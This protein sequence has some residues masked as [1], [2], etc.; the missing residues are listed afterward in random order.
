M[1]H[2]KRRE[3]GLGPVRLMTL[4]EASDAAPANRKVAR[5]GGDPRRTRRRSV[6][7]FERATAE[8]F[9]MRP[10]AVDRQARGPM[11]LD[12]PHVR[13]P[14]DR[15]EAGGPDHVGRHHGRAASDL[16]AI[17]QGYRVDNPAGEAIRAALPKPGHVLMH[18]KALPH[19]EVAGA[20]ETIRRSGAGALVKLSLEFLSLT[21]CRSGEGARGALDGD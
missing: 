6:P 18:R 14:E 4:A 13:A 19:G 21:A 5:A 10:H 2:G 20:I 11:G 8:V 16:G 3:L 9:A 17:A 12:A 1:I 15:R 7:T